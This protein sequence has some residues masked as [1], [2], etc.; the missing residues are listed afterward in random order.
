MNGILGGL[1]GPIGKVL[2]RFF[3]EEQLTATITYR[4]YQGQDQL[5]EDSF[6]DF[7]ITVIPAQKRH[8]NTTSAHRIPIQTG[9][10]SYIVREVDLPGS[11]TIDDL[12]T[13]DRIMHGDG[14]QELIVV[15]IDKTLGFV[16]EV[17]AR[18]E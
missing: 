11:V 13:N 9:D 14:T 16:V 10:R 7:Q 2:D 6:N 15:E 18:G 1:E 17:S 12:S 4:H 5:G 3:S 8:R